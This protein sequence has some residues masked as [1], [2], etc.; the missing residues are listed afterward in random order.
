MEGHALI[1]AKQYAGMPQGGGR[2]LAVRAEANSYQSCFS[3]TL[4]YN[5]IE[6]L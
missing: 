6:S 1:F 2:L 3:Q 5:V 4:G